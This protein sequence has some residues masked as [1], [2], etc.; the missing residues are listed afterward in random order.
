MTIDEIEFEPLQDTGKVQYCKAKTTGKYIHETTFF[1][2]LYDFKG[3]IHVY[4]Q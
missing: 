3:E 1:P 2:N 4:C